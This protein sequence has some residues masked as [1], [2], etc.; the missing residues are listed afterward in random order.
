MQQYK[1]HILRVSVLGVVQLV[2]NTRSGAYCKRCRPYNHFVIVILGTILVLALV[3]FHWL[4]NDPVGVPLSGVSEFIIL[5]GLSVSI[6]FYL[7]SLSA[8]AIEWEEPLAPFIDFGL[9]L[10][11]PGLEAWQ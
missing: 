6:L 11:A 3:A 8:L 10:R 9:T 1:F 2:C 7:S 5:M 4:G